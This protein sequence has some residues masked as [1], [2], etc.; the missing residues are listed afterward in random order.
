MSPTETDFS[1]RRRKPS[2]SPSAICWRPRALSRRPRSP[3]AS[4]SPMRRAPRS[5]PPSSPAPGPIPIIVRACWRTAP[6]RPR[7]WALRCAAHRRSACSRI[8]K[9]CITLSSAR[10]AAAIRARCS[11]IR[12]SGSN[13]LAIAPAPCAIRAACSRNGAR[14][15]GGCCD[16]CRR[17]D[18]RLPLDGAAAPSRRHR[19][20][21]RGP[22]RSHRAR[23]RHDRRHRA[24]DLSV[25]HRPPQSLL[26]LLTGQPSALAHSEG[27]GSLSSLAM[28]EAA[29]AVQTNGLGWALCSAR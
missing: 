28:I 24:V 10:C 16:P 19:R 2:S 20:L 25:Y 17:F 22:A 27:A 8:P 12:P 15:A 13:R 9:A 23:R 6:R 7:R 4:R 18:G 1:T 5:A 14:A 26:I 29:D 21:E 11:A 3:S